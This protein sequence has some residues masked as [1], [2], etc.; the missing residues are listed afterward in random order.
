[1]LYGLRTQILNIVPGK[2][3]LFFIQE[4]VSSR[5]IGVRLFRDSNDANTF[6]T[7]CESGLLQLKSIL[8]RFINQKG[9]H[10]QFK[11]VKKLGKGNFAS[12]YQVMRVEDGKKFAVK[13]FSKANTYN[14]ENGK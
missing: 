6:Y 13:A 1:M 7:N 2:R 14:S 12:V 8:S 9:F 11:P 3:I 5:K 4:N 10:A